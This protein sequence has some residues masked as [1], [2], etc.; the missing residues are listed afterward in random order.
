MAHK[1]IKHV[2]LSL[3]VCMLGACELHPTDISVIEHGNSCYRGQTVGGKPHG[4]GTLTVGDSLVYSGQW[5]NGMRQG[6]GET[7]DAQ[8]RTIAGQWDHDTL[9][10]GTRHDEGGVYCGSFDRLLR[11]NGY[12]TYHATDATHYEGIW[13]DDRRNGFGFSSQDRYFRVGEWKDDVFKGERLNY[14]TDRIYGIDISKHQHLVGRK[15]FAIDW[16]RLRII[17]LGTLSK[18][19]I[20]G[21]TDYKVSFLF[22][23]A[24][25]GTTVLNPYYAADYRA[26]R[27]HGVPV[28]SY[29]F[30]S[31]RTSGAL[32]ARYFLKNLH[33]QQG[34]L[35]PVLD[36]EPSAAQVAQ[37]GGAKA[38]WQQVRQWLTAVERH[39]GMR[40]I[41]YISQMFVNKYLNLAP[42]IKGG[43]P[44]WI[45]RYGE[46]K[47]DVKLWIWQLAPDGRVAGIHGSVDINVFNGYQ[48]EFEQWLHDTQKR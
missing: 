11:A 25:E 34:D 28:G 48:D 33:L 12:G 15:R 40:P 8:Q 21:A 41:L 43:Y 5:T 39:T 18:K 31:H 3:I 13:K 16:D 30:F 14:T 47:P 1:I 24:T 9:V 17:H 44:V 38:M 29:H 46:Y 36:V 26:A 7:R 27:R 20:R 42:D 37:M 10:S 23:K 6:Y 19:N 2:C 22:I 35:P 45:A 4:L 32:Q